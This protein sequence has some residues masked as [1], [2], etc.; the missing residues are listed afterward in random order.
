MLSPYLLMQVVC[1]ALFIYG[2]RLMNSPKTAVKGNLIGSV[3]MAGAIIMTLLEAQVLSVGLIWAGLLVGSA[4]GLWLALAVKMIQ[5]PQMVALFN[6]FGGAASC[7]VAALTALG[8][9]SGASPSSPLDWPWWWGVTFSGSL[10]AAAKLH[11]VINQRPVHLK[12]HN[13]YLWWSGVVMV[14]ATLGLTFQ[15]G[16]RPGLCCFWSSFPICS[17]MCSPS[18]WAARTCP[19]PFPS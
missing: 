15:V 6:G 19:S 13:A 2:I 8:E 16:P 7:I 10:V 11:G 12:G 17:A 14:L 4:L 3:G 9:G 18:G 5:M 1:I